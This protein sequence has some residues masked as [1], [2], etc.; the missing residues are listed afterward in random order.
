MR[1][2]TLCL[3]TLAFAA[4]AATVE[5]KSY[6]L[7]HRISPSSA[8]PSTHTTV[9][10]TEGTLNEWRP[11]AL[12]HVQDNVT[13]ED[14]TDAQTFQQLKKHVE[15]Q[16]NEKTRTRQ[17]Y[18]LKL[19]DEERR[20]VVGS[21]LLCH[22]AQSSAS[23]PQIHDTLTLHVRNHSVVSLRYTIDDIALDAAGCPVQT[24]HRANQ[25]LEEERKERAKRKAGI[26]RL[27]R[28]GRDVEALE[29]EE[30]ERER[31]VKVERFSTKVE[32]SEAV[33]SVAPNLRTPPTTNDDGTIQT[34]PPEKTFLQKY[35]IYILPMLVVLL[36][37]GGD[38]DA[39]KDET[40]N[41]QQQSQ[42]R[43]ARQVQ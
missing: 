14:V 24:E 1:I 27:K 12:I 2:P 15:K 40:T 17:R 7:Y 30:E 18:M 22:L 38:E 25:R 36:L 6:T 28:L 32:R 23:L 5:G 8:T 11:R 21:V 29:R 26:V 34:P 39:N 31:L 20:Q 37:P 41:T 3:L 35:W 10:H 42:G 9:T 16:R 4:C 33:R 13:L 19:E 43:G